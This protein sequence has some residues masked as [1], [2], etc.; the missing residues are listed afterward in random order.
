MLILLLFF[1]LSQIEVL[2]SLI[3][4]MASS[5]IVPHDFWKFSN[6]TSHVSTTSY[7]HR[8]G[9]HTIDLCS[10]GLHLRRPTFCHYILPEEEIVHTNRL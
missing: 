6:S 1:V 5:P 9:T 2:Q 4:F 7:S 3:S 8:T 10:F